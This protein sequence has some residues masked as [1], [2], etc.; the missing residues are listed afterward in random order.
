MQ[1]DSI[2]EKPDAAHSHY[3]LPPRWDPRWGPQP[4]WSFDHFEP[5][6]QSRETRSYPPPEPLEEESEQYILPANATLC[7]GP[8][9]N[10]AAS[11]LEGTAV[12]FSSIGLNERPDCHPSSARVYE[13][14]NLP[15][16]SAGLCYRTD[17][18]P[19]SAKLYESTH[20]PPTSAR[21]YE[22]ASLPPTS[23]KIYEASEG[24]PTFAERHE[25]IHSL[26]T[27]GRGSEQVLEAKVRRPI[28]EVCRRCSIFDPQ[29][30]GV[31]FYCY[32]RK[33]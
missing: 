15:P 5:L 22:A 12:A 30:Y 29:I 2:K 16:S 26:P 25:D 3:R 1:S 20:L 23:A 28:R 9:T 10:N 19:S 13:S 32:F 17:Q 8:L 27:P 31:C 33:D 4:D 7:N 14:T 21:A 18:P 11:L 6:N 24:P